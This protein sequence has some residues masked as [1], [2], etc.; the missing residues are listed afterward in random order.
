MSFRKRFRLFFYVIAIVAALVVAKIAIH[1]FGLEFLKLDAL[2]PSIVAGSVFVIGFLLSS[3]LP[4]YKEAERLPAEIRMALEAIHDDVITF[5]DIA[6]GTD[7]E[8][9]RQILTNIVIKLENGLGAHTDH[10]ALDTVADEI[11]LL[12]PVFGKLERLGMSQNFVVRL[13]GE[14]DILR[15]SLYRISYMQKMEFIPSVHVLIQTV[16]LATLFLLLFLKTEGTYTSTGVFGFV[17]YLFI[18]AMHLIEVLEQPFRKG[19]H[20][21]DDV[22]FFLLREFV[23]RIHHKSAAAR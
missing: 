12:T 11:D 10:K 2:L 9:F 21:V 22:S 23:D 18:Y 4:D 20:T 5:N 17:A 1:F 7:I 6:P 16:V 19:E 3:I 13:R 15:R 8:K 14:Q